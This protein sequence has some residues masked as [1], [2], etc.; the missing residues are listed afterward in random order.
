MNKELL[1]HNGLGRCVSRDFEQSSQWYL[2]VIMSVQVAF[3]CGRVYIIFEMFGYI[4]KIVNS[5]AGF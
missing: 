4:V 1:Q 3:Q 2:I 5:P